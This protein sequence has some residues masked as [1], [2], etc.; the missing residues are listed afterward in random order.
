L[1]RRACLL[2][3]VIRLW[4]TRC[5]R[6]VGPDGS[7]MNV[8]LMHYVK[9]LDE[10]RDLPA[11]PDDKTTASAVATTLLAFLRSLSVPVI[12][13]SLHPQIVA[14]VDREDAYTQLSLFPAA[15]VNV[16]L[17]LNQS[18]LVLMIL[19]DMGLPQCFS[20][21]SHPPASINYAGPG[22]NSGSTGRR[23]WYMHLL[24]HCHEPD[25]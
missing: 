5:A 20:P 25:L 6:Y 9:A 4:S 1:F 24:Y 16:S 19:S 3:R 10:D 11:G 18:T 21:L 13:S 12:P 14:T 8:S 23:V 22:C 2:Y 15:S 7:V 17:P